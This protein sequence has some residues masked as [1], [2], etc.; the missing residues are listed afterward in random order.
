MADDF[1]VVR[2]VI[3]LDAVYVMAVQIPFVAT[4]ISIVVS[5]IRVLAHPVDFF[6]F[7]Q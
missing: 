2:H 4:E 3:A 5:M 1:Q 7:P 6:F